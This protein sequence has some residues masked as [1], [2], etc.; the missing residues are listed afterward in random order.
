MTKPL[1]RISDAC[2]LAKRDPATLSITAL[3]CIWSPDLIAGRPGFAENLLTGT[4]WEIAEA[5]RGYA[6]LGVQHVMFQCERYT[7][8]S[9]RRLTEALQIYHRMYS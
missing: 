6:E 3:V 9:R 2:R 4:T 1:A 7:P 5:I 8:E